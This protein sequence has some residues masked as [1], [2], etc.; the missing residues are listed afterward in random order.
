MK[1]YVW[2]AVAPA[3]VLLMAGCAG[4]GKVISGGDNFSS[5]TATGGKASPAQQ[6]AFEKAI[7]DYTQAIRLA[8]DYANAY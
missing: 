2:R 5:F 3:L 1:G 6:Q 8:P 7:A 4:V